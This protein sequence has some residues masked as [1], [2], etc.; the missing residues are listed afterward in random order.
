[1]RHR[2][3]TKYLLGL[4]KSRIDDS[5][6]ELSS[7][8]NKKLKS[9]T[10]KA[11][12]ARTYVS[13]LT[14]FVK[15][16]LTMKGIGQVQSVNLSI[17][18][19]R[20]LQFT[21]ANWIK[22][23]SKQSQ[24]DAKDATKR[25]S[26]SDVVNP[27]DV[28]KYL[29]CDRAA[30]AKTVIESIHTMSEGCQISQENHTLIRNYL[31]FCLAI[32]NAQRSGCLMNMTLDEF[33]E[34]KKIK[35]KDHH[36]IF[37]KD[38][39]TSSTYGSAELIVTPELYK[40]MEA[41]VLQRPTSTAKEIFLTWNGNKMTSANVVHSLTTEIAH[42]GVDKRFVYMPCMENVISFITL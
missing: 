18:G 14:L 29:E 2:L 25:L 3:Q 9:G 10:W 13:S 17:D 11:N 22:S 33:T 35:R 19:L 41:Y 7:A 15:F 21:M 42:A 39:K 36:I 1:M 31:L 37:V 20:A 40:M 32:S 4:V 34:G 26:E 5:P 27:D 16:L 12:T 24:R 23:L 38:H 30:K 6:E 28:A 8:L